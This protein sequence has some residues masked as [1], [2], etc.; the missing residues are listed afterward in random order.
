MPG[1]LY[2][3]PL[4]IKVAYTG[5]PVFIQ[6]RIYLS[7]QSNIAKQKYNKVKMFHP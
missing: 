4:F 3:V 2:Q 6:I 1:L 5:Y 7:V